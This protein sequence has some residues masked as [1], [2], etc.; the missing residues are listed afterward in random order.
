MLKNL[1]TFWD[2]ESKSLK[3]HNSSKTE[4]EI[5]TVYVSGHSDSSKVWWPV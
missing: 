3:I 2:L 5:L 1:H 4:S